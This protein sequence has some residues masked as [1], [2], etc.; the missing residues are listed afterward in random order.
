MEDN[1]KTI[2]LYDTEK[3]QLLGVFKSIELSAR[4]LFTNHSERHTSRMHHALSRKHKISHETIFDFPV[5]IRISNQAQK[6]LLGNKSCH[7]I[8][9]YPQRMNDKGQ[10]R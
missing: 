8:Q 10:V 1:S 4:Y 6:D 5:A 3:K 2:S 9:E 7:I